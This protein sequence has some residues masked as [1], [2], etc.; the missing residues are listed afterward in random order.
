M[1]FFFS[2]SDVFVNYVIKKK[3]IRKVLICWLDVLNS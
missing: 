2:N 3:I 1:G